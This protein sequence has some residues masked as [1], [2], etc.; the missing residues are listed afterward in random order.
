MEMG[1]IKYG[2]GAIQ[3]RISRTI[4][5]IASNVLPGSGQ[6]RGKQVAMPATTKL[7]PREAN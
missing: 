4:H 1:W 7:G 2:E 5:G 6:L 3:P